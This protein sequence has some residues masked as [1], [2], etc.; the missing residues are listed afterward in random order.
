[1]TFVASIICV[2]DTEGSK[3]QNI[4]KNLPWNNDFYVKWI[5]LLYFNV[6]SMKVGLKYMIFFNWTHKNLNGLKLFNK[7]YKELLI[8]FF[9]KS[10]TI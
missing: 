10:T 2:A 6:F 5:T 8:A 1:M 9:T 4:C 7:Y 3:W